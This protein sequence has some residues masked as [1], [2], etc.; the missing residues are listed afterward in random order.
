MCRQICYFRGASL[1]TAVVLPCELDQIVDQWAGLRSAMTKDLPE[2]F[3]RDEWAYLVSFL[4]PANL[5][6]PFEMSFGPSL[7]SI[8]GKVD[9][10]MRP[11]GPVAIWLPNNVS[12]LGPLTLILMS[13][14]GNPISIKGGSQSEDLTGI[15]LEFVRRHL[16][17]G[18][19][20]EFLTECVKYDVFERDDP[21]NAYMAARAEIRIVFG[22]KPAA[23]S[24]HALPHPAESIGF[25]FIDRW[26]EAWIEKDAVTDEVL[27]DLLKVFA[28]YG[29]AGCTSPR[30]VVL[31]GGS[32]EQ[33]VALR[34]RLQ[35][36]W[37]KTIKRRPAMHVAS[38]NIMAR[39]WAAALGWD[40]VTTGQNAAVM[41]AGEASL[42]N[43]EAPM[44]MMLT[45]GKI[46]EAVSNLPANIQTLG[47]AFDDPGQSQWLQIMAQIKA[48][49]LVPISLMHHFGPVWDGVAFWRQA[50][51]EIEL[52]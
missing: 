8:S 9:I 6:R 47:Y 36:L 25:S 2:G 29:Q 44:A 21:K 27:S 20:K 39:Q 51:E 5:I 45:Y 41:A 40:A 52:Q 18:Y 49:R 15:F 50:F 38:S 42:E 19:L 46:A 12:L 10:L 1:C 37:P 24:I 48:K 43:F 16:P 22:T 17:D 30:R 33:T 34:D 35:A 14:T 32:M 11:R 26:S 3:S 23:E 7:T 28:V 13:L 31:L 4:N